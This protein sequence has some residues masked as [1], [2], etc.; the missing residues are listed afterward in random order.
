MS[1]SVNEQRNK[2]QRWLEGKV[3]VTGS[4]LFKIS[5]QRD[6]SVKASNVTGD[7]SRRGECW[8]KDLVNSVGD[9]QFVCSKRMLNKRNMC[10]YLLY[11]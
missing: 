7:E 4:S 5:M 6:I 10:I 8:K 2:M 3:V 11:I 9:Q 1:T